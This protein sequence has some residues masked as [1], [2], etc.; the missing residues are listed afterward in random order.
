MR[1]C[2]FDPATREGHSD[3]KNRDVF[4][5]APRGQMWGDLPDSCLSDRPQ[6]SWSTCH[7]PQ[8]AAAAEPVDRQ[9]VAAR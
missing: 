5:F 7:S 8:P 2:A 9:E 3:D 1:A 6:F 4:H